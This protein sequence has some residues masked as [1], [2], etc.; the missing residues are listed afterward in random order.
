[1]R[2]SALTSRPEWT[3]AAA[4]D[5]VE[6][7]R[8][9]A[10]VVRGPGPADCWLWTGAIADDGYGRF[11]IRRN[12]VVR[13]VRPH[14]YAL[15]LALQVGLDDVEVAE[16]AVCDVPICVGA[17]GK[18]ATTSGPLPRPRTWHGWAGAGGAAARTGPAGSAG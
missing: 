17:E 5:R 8:F 15:A 2:R 1:M 6:V 7:A 4:G 3:V 14:R 16:H 9:G 12:G 10:K 13:V 18:Q 11:W